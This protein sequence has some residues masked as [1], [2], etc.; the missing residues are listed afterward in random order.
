MGFDLNPYDPCVANKVFEGRQ[1]TIAWYVDDNKIS[2]VNPSVVTDFVAK[3][4]E[5]FGKM[6]VTRGKSMLFLTTEQQ[7]YACWTT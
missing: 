6:T 7:R 4:E 1:Y 3:I 5:R 2:H